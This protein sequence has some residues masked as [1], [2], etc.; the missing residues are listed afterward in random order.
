MR[1][2]AVTISRHEESWDLPDVPWYCLVRDEDILGEGS[3]PRR[4]ITYL[5][6]KRN[7]A[8]KLALEKYPDATD[9]IICDTYYLHQIEGLNR[10]ISDYQKI[11][12]QG[13]ALGGAIW[14]TIRLKLEH[15]FRR[16]R[17]EWY[18]KWAVPELAF[19]PYRWRPETDVVARMFTPPLPG[20][21]YTSAL[22][23]VAIW[24]R[25]VWDKGARFGVNDDLHGCEMN[26]FYESAGIPRYIDLDAV[27]WRR[28]VYPLSKC[29]RNTLHL[30]RLI[31]K[32]GKKPYEDLLISKGLER[33]RKY[34]R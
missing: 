29:I 34:K 31:G 7:E 16:P 10:L 1:L 26:R 15:Y 4:Y 6:E 14:G 23:G 27:F 30:G 3:P 17:I 13:V 28:T 2:V 24:P 25:S 8:V 18:D 20:L 9:I 5:A 12:S 11:R 19:V 33:M 32:K 22:S 21:Y